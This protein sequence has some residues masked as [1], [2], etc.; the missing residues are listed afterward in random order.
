LPFKLNLQRYNEE[1]GD[2]PLTSF[3]AAAEVLALDPRFE[4]CPL[5]ER[6][7]QYCAHV[8]RLC[9]EVGAEL[10]PDVAALQEELKAA[11]AEEEEE[12]RRER[13]EEMLGL[14]VSRGRGGGGGGGGREMGR[15]GRGRERS[16]SRSRSRDRGDRKKKRSRSRS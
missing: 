4:K 1:G 11:R 12:R 13:D 9:Q 8:E 16:R 5:N 3:V 14:K 15:G 2:N 6:A 7:A 10:P